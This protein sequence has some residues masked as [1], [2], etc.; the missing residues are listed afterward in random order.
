MKR[1]V[2][3]L[4][5]G[6]IAASALSAQVGGPGNRGY[7][8]PGA[9]AVQSAEVVKVEGKLVLVNG[10]VAVKDKDKTYYVGGLN[11][12][13]GFIDGLKENASVKLE[14][15]A[16]AVPAAPEYQHLRVTKLTFNGKDYDLSN[17]FGRGMMGG[18]MRGG[19]NNQAGRGGMMGGYGRR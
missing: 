7:F 18:G 15:Y 1:I 9:A 13:I 4:V 3:L 6:V 8:G 5:I 16:I 19:Y 14:G 2:T 17:S 12:L 11:R 10:M